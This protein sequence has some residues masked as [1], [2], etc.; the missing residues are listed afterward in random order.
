MRRNICTDQVNFFTMFSLTRCFSKYCNVR[1]V[2]SH[3][4][5]PEKMF[6]SLKKFEPSLGKTGESKIETRVAYIKPVDISK[7]IAPSNLQDF[8]VREKWMLDVFKRFF[9][10]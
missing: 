9:K 2:H 7:M 5:D 6:R 10:K 4:Y 3:A 1:N 8:F